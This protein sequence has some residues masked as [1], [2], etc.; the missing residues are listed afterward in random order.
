LPTSSTAFNAPTKTPC[1]IVL[2][3]GRDLSGAGAKVE[4]LPVT[5][6]YSAQGDMF[7]RAVLGMAPLDYEIEDA[8]LNMRVIDAVRRAAETGSWQAI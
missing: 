7:S 3:D 5:D 8:V 4:D 6:Q 1:R 2:D